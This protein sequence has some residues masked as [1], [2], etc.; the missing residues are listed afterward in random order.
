MGRRAF[1]LVVCSALLAAFV[2]F[3]GARVEVA[4]QKLKEK[5]DN[6]LGQMDLKRKEIEISVDGLKEGINGLRKAK[7]KAQVSSE[8]IQ[9]RAR[10]Q[11]ERLASMDKALKTLG[12]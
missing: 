7:I 12:A 10:P 4:G 3:R 5:I 6:I 2:L 9:R 8:Q 11:E 1:W